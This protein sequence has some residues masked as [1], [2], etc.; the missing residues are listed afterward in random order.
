VTAVLP[1]PSPPRADRLRR[2]MR[3]PAMQDQPLL[4]R[5]P[6][7][8]HTVVGGILPIPQLRLIVRTVASAPRP[9][10]SK[11]SPD[12]PAQGLPVT[13]NAGIGT[14]AALTATPPLH[15]ALANRPTRS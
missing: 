12:F 13:S 2:L 4:I 9:A 1:A 11:A 14:I 15:G 6:R 3:V 8:G 10:S 7:L 5:A